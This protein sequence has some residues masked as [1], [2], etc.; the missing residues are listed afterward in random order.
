MPQA[1]IGF[2]T[3]GEYSPAPGGGDIEHYLARSLGFALLA[4]GLVTVVLT[5]SL[6]VGSVIDSKL[7]FFIFPISPIRLSCLSDLKR[8]T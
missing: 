2:L 1:I 3:L 7:V 6:P 4:L 8:Q 5:G